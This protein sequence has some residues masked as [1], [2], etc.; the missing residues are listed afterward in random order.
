MMDRGRKQVK[1]LKKVASP[2]IQLVCNSH[3]R[4]SH[5][6]IS[7]VC[8]AATMTLPTRCFYFRWKEEWV[9]QVGIALHMARRNIVCNRR[10]AQRFCTYKKRLKFMQKIKRRSP[11]DI[12]GL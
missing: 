8:C 5:G 4:G 10:A 12:L 1:G 6:D 11:V 7:R 2:W 9:I 3:L